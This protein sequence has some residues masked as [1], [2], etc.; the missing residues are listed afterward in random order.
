M[1]IIHK[2]SDTQKRKKRKNKITKILPVGVFQIFEQ[3]TVICGPGE[4]QYNKIP[5]TL[6]AWPVGTNSTCFSSIIFF[7]SSTCA[8]PFKLKVTINGQRERSIFEPAQ[9][10]A[11]RRPF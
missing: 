5:W 6:A 7:S 2:D 9:N 4:V 11:V 10:T 1:G 8:I 3:D